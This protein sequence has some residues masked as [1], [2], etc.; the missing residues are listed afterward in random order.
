MV[1]NPTLAYLHACRKATGSSKGLTRGAMV[2]MSPFP[3]HF[4]SRN[5]AE[6]PVRLLLSKEEVTD[7]QGHHAS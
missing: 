1:V 3:L 7:V 2:I 4:V 5:I 6:I